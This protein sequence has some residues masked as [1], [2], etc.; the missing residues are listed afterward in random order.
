MHEAYQQPAQDLVA[1][2]DYN[3]KGIV[4]KFYR[5]VRKMLCS[6]LDTKLY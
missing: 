5:K 3:S 1:D 4:S 2:R 6:S